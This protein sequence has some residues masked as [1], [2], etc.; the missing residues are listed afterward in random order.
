M[1][2][3]DITILYNKHKYDIQSLVS[4][5]DPAL[6]YLLLVPASLPVLLIF[7]YTSWLGWQMFVNN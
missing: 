6:Y 7:C 1:Y 5:L 3:C 2:N 4:M